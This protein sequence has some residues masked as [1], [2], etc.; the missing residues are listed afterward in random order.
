MGSRVVWLGVFVLLCGGVG[1]YFYSNRPTISPPPVVETSKFDK[2]L[3]EKIQT[4][5]NN[6]NASQRNG[7]AWGEYGMVLYANDL[8]VP[9]MECFATA[10]KLDATNPRWSYLQGHH[11]VKE[12]PQT[13]AEHF[14]NALNKIT[15]LEVKHRAVAL[16]QLAEIATRDGNFEEAKSLLEQM[17]NPN[18]YPDRRLYLLGLMSMQRKKYQEV[19][20]E[21]PKLL[22]NPFTTKRASDLLIQAAKESNQKD[23]A[24]KYEKQAKNLV[25]IDWEDPFMEEVSTQREGI[26][27][28]L[29]RIIFFERTNEVNRAKE[30]GEQ[31]VGDYPQEDV[32]LG[33]GSLYARTRDYKRAGE[34]LN[35]ALALNPKNIETLFQLGLM[36]FVQ[37]RVAYEEGKPETA[38]PLLNESVTW[39][40]KLLKEKPDHVSALGTM[41]TALGYA[42]KRTQGLSVIQGAKKLHPDRYDFCLVE[43]ELWFLEKDAEKMRAAIKEAEKIAP[44]NREVQQAKQELEY[45]L[46]NP[47]KK[48]G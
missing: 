33:V 22:A 5:Y 21:L 43:A 39:F 30:I 28:R 29:T 36:N 16:Y 25:L 7:K 42:G 12:N 44:N 19:L 13:A 11:L 8:P 4:S 46:T 9:A 10:E 37:G 24:E 34:L 3:T 38:T 40:E 32:L 14:K 6:V 47:P 48:K 17:P 15:T 31:L 1:Y 23:L 41:S 26:K 2:Y 45:R 18:P 35:K 20:D 27:A